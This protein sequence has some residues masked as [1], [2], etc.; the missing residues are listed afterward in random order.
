MGSSTDT[1]LDIHLIVNNYATHKHPNVQ[2]RLEK[3][4]RF[5]R[6]FTPT[7]WVNFVERFFRDIT[8][9]TYSPQGLP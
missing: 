5:H 2:A 8:E 4:S 9:R 7:S 1:S 3:N 6:H